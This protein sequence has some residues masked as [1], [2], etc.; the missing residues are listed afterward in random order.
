[1]ARS[2]VSLKPQLN[3][4]RTWLAEGATD[5]WIAH[6]LGST[7]A[8]IASFRRAN[9]LI[10]RSP[11]VPDADSPSRLMDVPQPESASSEPESVAPSAEEA[12][13]APAAA[14]A[15][16]APAKR[17]RSRRPAKAE[18]AAPD[19]A[20]PVVEVAPEAVADTV[21]P[22]AGAPATA[23]EEDRDE[24]GDDEGGRRRR[25]GRRG[26]RNR[27]P[28]RDA[29]GREVVAAGPAEPI[30]LEGV[31]DHGDEG[32]GLWLD[33]AIKDAPVYRQNW[34]GHRSLVVSVTA[35]QIVLRRAPQN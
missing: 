15:P 31:F 27:R 21:P 24:D 7:P 5:I 17:P 13:L 32:Y 16:A 33:G 4:I 30:E 19:S 8:S 1:M 10:R 12:T 2:R 28:A 20:D 29:N 3:Q 22:A 25:R 35:D 18:T 9:G 14:A 26:G 34:A 23:P 11:D 6:Q